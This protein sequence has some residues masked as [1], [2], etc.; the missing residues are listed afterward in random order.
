[1][2]NDITVTMRL[3]FDRE[4]LEK[5]LID[6]HSTN[7]CDNEKKIKSYKDEMLADI[8]ASTLVYMMYDNKISFQNLPKIFDG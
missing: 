1:M 3:T 7:G 4:K 8:V 6:Y 5:F 2:G